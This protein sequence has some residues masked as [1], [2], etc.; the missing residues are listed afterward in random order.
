[1]KNKNL[2]ID[3]IP[4]QFDSYEEAG[5]FWDNHD[6]T[7]Y[8]EDFVTVEVNSKLQQKHYEIEIDLDLIQHLKNQAKKQQVTIQ[9]L[10]NQI[11][12]EKIFS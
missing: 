8:L 3:P 10:V 6:T 5:E 1:M 7:D 2:N 11:L 12:R 4:E 9:D